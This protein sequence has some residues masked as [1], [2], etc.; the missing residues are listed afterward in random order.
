MVCGLP[1]CGSLWV[2]V[3]TGS[4]PQCVMSAAEGRSG[5]ATRPIKGVEL[6]ER[7]GRLEP[8][9]HRVGVADAAI[10]P[11]ARPRI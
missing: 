2:L 1:R 8:A 9:Q 11:A 7:L 6:A 3:L 10:A 5:S 4:P